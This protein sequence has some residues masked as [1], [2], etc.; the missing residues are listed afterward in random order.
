MLTEGKPT[1][2]IL[3]Y[4]LSLEGEEFNDTDGTF[5]L[6]Y[7]PQKLDSFSQLLKEEF[8]DKSE[9]TI[10]GDFKSLDVV[11]KP[12]FYIHLIEKPL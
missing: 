8:G 11:P 7:Y 2:V 4:A 12:K 9:H 3:D 10:Y 1:M 5:R 6:S